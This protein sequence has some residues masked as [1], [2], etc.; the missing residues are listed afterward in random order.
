M[1]LEFF[2]KKQPKNVGICC[3]DPTNCNTCGWNPEEAERR[4]KETLEKLKEKENEE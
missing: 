1:K 2:C 3:K 4:H